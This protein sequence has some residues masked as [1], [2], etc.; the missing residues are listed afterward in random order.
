VFEIGSAK[1]KWGHLFSVVIDFA[2]V[3]VVVYFGFRKLGL[4]R[5]DKKA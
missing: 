2:A 5:L 4:D 1:I 3:A